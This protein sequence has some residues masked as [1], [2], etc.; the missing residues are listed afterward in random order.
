LKGQKLEA[1]PRRSWLALALAALTYTVISITLTGTNIAFPAITDEFSGTSRSTLSWALSGYSIA[2]ATFMVPAGRLSDRSGRRRMFFAGVWLF[3][4]ASV[5]CFL[6]PTANVFVAGR[7]LQGIGGSLTVP[8]SLALVLPAFPTSRRTSAVAAW[9]AS[10]TVGAAIAPS[11]SAVIVENLGWRYVYL[12]AVPVAIVVLVGGR[13]L[14]SESEPIVDGKKLD[15]IGFPLGTIAIGLIAFVI[16]QSPRLGWSHT[17]IVVPMAGVICLLPVFVMRSLRHPAPLLDL[18]VFSARPVWTVTLAG[19]IFSMLGA[20]TWVVWPLFLTEVWDYSLVQAGLAI[21]PAPICASGFGLLSGYLADRFGRRP[22]IAFGTLFPIAAMLTMALR[23]GAEPNYLTG[24]LPAILLFGTGFGL[25]FSSL[26]AAALDGQP[27]AMFGEVN[28][29][30]NTVRNLASGLGV[31]AAVAI[32]GDAD[33]IP[34]ERF[35]RFF[36]VFALFAAAPAIVINGFYPRSQ[37]SQAIRT[38]SGSD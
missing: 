3:L 22:L 28:A 1:V 9:T 2:L 25:T 31:A 6:A 5:V 36:F 38:V 30:F 4:F 8:T 35:D 29:G 13:R 32:L 21:T 34:F 11:L 7:I 12:M 37:H 18:R 19:L 27:E 16:V 33:N 10:G 15:L 20:S 14:L 17:A 23:W 24:F 26:N